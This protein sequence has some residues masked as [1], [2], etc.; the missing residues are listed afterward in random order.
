MMRQYEL[1]DRVRRYNPQ[2]D[3]DILNRAYVYAMQ[4]HGAQLEKPEWLAVFAGSI[5]DV[6][7]RPGIDQFDG[8]DGENKHRQYQDAGQG[9]HAEVERTAAGQ[10]KLRLRGYSR[11]EGYL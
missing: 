3:E 7:R 8:D 10:R 11:R 4:A 9:S 6:E 2:A 5:L 1:V